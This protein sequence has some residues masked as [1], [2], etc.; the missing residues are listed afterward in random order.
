LPACP[1][2]KKKRPLK[3]DIKKIKPSA[4]KGFQEGN[5]NTN[6]R[7]AKMLILQNLV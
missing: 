3:K 7:P 4:K 6:P 2:Q 1:K 5:T